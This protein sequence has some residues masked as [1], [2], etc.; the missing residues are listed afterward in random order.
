MDGYLTFEHGQ[1]RLGGTTLPGILSSQR[2]KGAVQ[3]D[4]ASPDGMSGEVK[5]PMGWEDGDVVIV[6]DLL[7][8]DGSSCYDKAAQIDGLFKGHDNNA[9]PRVLN[10]VNPH[11]AARGVEKVVFSGFETAETDRDDVIVA[12]LRFTE[13]NPIITKTERAANA[14]PTDQVT[15]SPGLAGGI[16]EESR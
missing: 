4:T 10:V 3:F 7:T 5:T 8:E 16:S 1:V 14:R 12:T 13:H 9:N 15:Q 6:L 2:V 11:L